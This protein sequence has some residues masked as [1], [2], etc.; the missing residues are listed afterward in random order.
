[1]TDQH[2][3]NLYTTETHIQ[4]TPAKAVPAWGWRFKN[5]KAPAIVECVK[6]YLQPKQSYK[7]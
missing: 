5:C 7:I 6:K 1:M 4:D 3:P 2:D